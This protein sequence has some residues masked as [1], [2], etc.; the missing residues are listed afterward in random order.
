LRFSTLAK[1]FRF[2]R[3]F[4][5]GRHGEQGNT[6]WMRDFALIDGT[7]VG[8]G[9]ERIRGP[10]GGGFARVYA[11][12]SWGRKSQWPM[13]GH[14]GG[15]FGIGGGKNRRASHCPPRRAS[16]RA[17][18]HTNRHPNGGTNRARHR[19]GMNEET[20]SQTQPRRHSLGYTA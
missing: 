17:S 7:G 20:V 11:T 4:A 9:T 2:G 13:E 12:D 6:R 3:N 18:H 10:G 16:H 5:A 15:G 14:L 1:E 19:K 8:G